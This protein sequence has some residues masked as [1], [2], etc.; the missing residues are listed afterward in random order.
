MSKKKKSPAAKAKQGHPGRCGS[1]EQFEDVQAELLE[2]LDEGIESTQV[3]EAFATFERAELDEG[4][5]TELAVDLMVT[6]GML[7]RD[8]H[9]EV[10]AALKKLLAFAVAE[11]AGLEVNYEDPDD[12]DLAHLGA[13][14]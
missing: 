8:T 12:E 13:D 2:D 4:L 6:E 5:L 7:E 3:A 9:L 1:D 14:D 10:P 11:P